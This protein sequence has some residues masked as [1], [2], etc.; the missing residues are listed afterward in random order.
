[1]S[2][3]NKFR[4]PIS[5]FPQCRA[6]VQSCRQVVTLQWMDS[7]AKHLTYNPPNSAKVALA[8]A[9]TTC[10]NEE[11]PGTPIKASTSN[12]I[13]EISPGPRGRDISWSS[14]V[15]LITSDGLA[16]KEKLRFKDERFLFLLCAAWERNSFTSCFGGLFAF[17][18]CFGFRRGE[19]DVFPPAGLPAV[20]KCLPGGVR[21]RSA[22]SADSVVPRRERWDRGKRVGGG[23]CRVLGAGHVP[24][25]S[26][27]QRLSALH[28]RRS[29]SFL[30]DGKKS[31][32]TFAKAARF[33]FALYCFYSAS[34]P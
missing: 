28:Q 6:A 19:G 4:V 23:R 26:Q 27:L 9:L 3:S 17:L 13:W 32:C 30:P 33:C 31:R 24:V 5:S 7:N 20:F 15:D 14:I 2:H 22:G 10:A 18:P 1:M 8:N 16:A 12:C 34:V 29:G 21:R 11:E 25:R